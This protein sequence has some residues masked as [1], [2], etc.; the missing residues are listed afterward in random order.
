[1]SES[2]FVES[3]FHPTDFSEESHFAFAHALALALLRKAELTILHSGRDFLA[4]DSWTKFPAVRKTL[5]SWGCLEPGSPRSAVLEQLDILIK[6]VN[7]RRRNPGDAII[8]YLA[9]HETDL[10]V[11]ATHGREGLPG[12]LRPSIAERVARETR[13][14]TLF[15]PGDGRG[16]V[17]PKTGAIYLSRVL[18]PAT[19]APSA[20][21]ALDYAARA[22]Q[23]ADP[24]VE[25]VLLHVGAGPMP[26]LTRPQDAGFRFREE[27]RTGDVAEE[28]VRAAEEMRVDLIAMTTDGRD[29]FLGALGRGSHTEQVVRGARCPV[30]AVP[31]GRA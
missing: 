5:E 30:L 6:K 16:F 13:T 3:I 27:R 18:I 19:G 31:V 12:W 22:G 7:L 20:Q 1:V 24:P 28:I 21:R 25:F 23:I 11:V 8:E 10:I 15:V 14:M 2:P 9:G 26:T 29:G 4:E 17:N